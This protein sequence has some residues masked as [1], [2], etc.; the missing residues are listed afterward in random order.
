[1]K[2]TARADGHRARRHSVLPF[3]AL[4]A[5][6]L[7]GA[8]TASAQEAEHGASGEHP[9]HAG[10]LPYRHVI[11]LFAGA[12]TH[13]EDNDT[14]GAVGLSYGYKLSHQWA[15]GIK[16]EYAGSGLERDYIILPG[17]VFEPV[18]RV[19]LALG[20]GVEQVSRDKLEDGEEHTVE[21][22]EALLRLTF[23]Y[24]FPLGTNLALT[25]E[26]NAD[27]TGPEEVTYVYGLVLSVGL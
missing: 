9:E 2:S 20:L 4:A 16:L 27:I 15:V 3:V 8:P 25:P 11:S 21:E 14:G 23:G 17:V 6:I 1:M 26:F 10:A 22:T 24:V 12:A 13:T 18:E 7:V 5:A 19:E